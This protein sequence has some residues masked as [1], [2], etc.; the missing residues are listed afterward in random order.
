MF[1]VITEYIG[2]IA[3]LGLFYSSDHAFTLRLIDFSLKCL[4]QWKGFPFTMH[5]HTISSSIQIGFIGI[6]WFIG[7]AALFPWFLGQECWLSWDG[8]CE[9]GCQEG[10]FWCFLCSW[11]IWGDNFILSGRCA[12]RAETLFVRVEQK[13]LSIDDRRLEEI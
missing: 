10:S 12:H 1:S 3:T 8:C 9:L 6:G 2:F 13:P 7:M 5:N 11:S 4:S